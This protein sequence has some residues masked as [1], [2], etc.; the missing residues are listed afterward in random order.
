MKKL[1][2]IMM[3]AAASALVIGCGDE[4]MSAK[5]KEYAIC[6]KMVKDYGATSCGPTAGSTTGSTTVTSTVTVT[7]T[8]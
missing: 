6:G 5:E 3:L 8:N 7:S 1:P 2:L 4:G